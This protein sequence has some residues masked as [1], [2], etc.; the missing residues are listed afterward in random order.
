MKKFLFLGI[1]LLS[2]ISLS[3]TSS[4]YQIQN[5]L[6][7]SVKDFGASGGQIMIINSQNN[8]P[9]KIF[10]IGQ[11]S[12]KPFNPEH[13]KEC[14][15][16]PLFYKG[17]K[18]LTYSCTFIKDTPQHVETAAYTEIILNKQK[19]KI[20]TAL[21]EPKPKR[22]TFGFTTAAWNALPLLDNILR[23]L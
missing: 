4:S 1:F 12:F 10:T 18:I 5:I 19:Y 8:H 3:L 21:N 14:F 17:K 15:T 9:E 23:L 2:G 13:K 6:Q 16:K 20:W 7:K 22:K 11:Y